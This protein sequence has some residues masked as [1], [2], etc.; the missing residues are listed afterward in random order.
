MLPFKQTCVASDD[1][2]RKSV[3]LSIRYVCPRTP[4]SSTIAP[5]DP[6]LDVLNFSSVDKRSDEIAWPSPTKVPSCPFPDLS[7]G[8]PSSKDQYAACFDPIPEISR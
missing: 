5:F 3:D 7:I 6:K 1:Q 8:V 4:S 2:L